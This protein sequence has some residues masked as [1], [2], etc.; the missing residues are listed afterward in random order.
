MQPEGMNKY[1]FWM[2]QQKDVACQT[3]CA[4]NVGERLKVKG[5]GTYPE[6]VAPYPH[7]G[8]PNIYDLWQSSPTVI[9]AAPSFDLLTQPSRAGARSHQACH[10]CWL[11]E[12]LPADAVAVS[13][14][15]LPRRAVAI[16]QRTM[17]C[18]CALLSSA[19][20]QAFGSVFC[21]VC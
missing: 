21:S 14:N 9:V 1:N 19:T 17:P 18:G 12:P 2:M 15:P 20:I 6:S 8:I 5:P 3:Q 10:V 11:P 13:S 4:A 7:A 16:I